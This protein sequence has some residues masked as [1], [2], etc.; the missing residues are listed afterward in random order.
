V[1]PTTLTMRPAHHSTPRIFPGRLFS[2]AWL[3]AVAGFAGPGGALPVV[4]AASANLS[5]ELFFSE[6]EVTQLRF[7][8]N[9]RYLAALV[10]VDRRLNL[11]IVD[12]QSGARELITRLSDEGILTYRWANDDRLIFLRDEDGRESAGLFGVNRTGGVVDR[13]AYRGERARTASI[14]TRFGGLLRRDSTNP[15]RFL[16]LSYETIRDRPDVVA[17]DVR[18]GAT[19]IRARNPGNVTRWILDWDDVVRIGIESQDDGRTRILYRDSSRSNWEV[20]DEF[21][22]GEPSWIPLAFEGDNRT[23]YVASNRGRTTSAL[24]RYDTVRRAMGELVHADDTYD[25]VGSY[26]SLV[27]SQAQRRVVGVRYERERPAVVYWDPEFARRQMIIDRALPGLANVQI[28]ATEDGR[29]FLVFSYSDREPGVYYVFDEAN[30]RIQQLV[31]IRPR[32]DPEA[33]AERRPVSLLA[34][35]GMRLHGYL[36]LPPKAVFPQP[37]IIIPHGGPYGVRDVWGFDSEAQFLASRGYVVMQINYRGSGGYGLAF[38]Q[39]GYQRW[40]LE[41]QDDL[42]DAVEW[43]IREGYTARNLVGIYGASYGGYAAMAGAAFTPDLYRVAINYVGVTDLV[44]MFGELRGLPS[45]RIHWVRTRIGDVND[46]SVMARLADTSPA[47]HADRIRV[48]VLMGYGRNDPRV[49]INQGYVMADAL[50]RAGIE[51]EFI[52]ETD[53]GHGFRKEEKS[54]AW[55]Q[56]VERFLQQ[57]LPVVTDGKGFN[58]ISGD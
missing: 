46:R 53:E 14:N 8:P 27:T 18:S 15:N 52:I 6:P 7:S 16:V 2:T 39:A 33:M 29:L 58:Q 17:M 25:V 20:L 45:Q 49:P 30:R 44:R 42:T 41:M 3:L 21:T 36:T 56:T 40:G 43:A 24:Y 23:L 37:L 55:Y 34:R 38:E 4:A 1:S 51:H 19:T 22:E 13:L 31:A 26:G 35:D 57:H 54:I 10:P 50:R 12:L 32:I 47:R 9:G 28:E 11:A 5:V 48:P